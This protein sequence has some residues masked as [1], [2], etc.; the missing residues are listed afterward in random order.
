MTE[1]TEVTKEELDARQRL[2]EVN[3]Q[4]SNARVIL[5]QI[6]AETGDYLTKREK[7]A[8]ER[9]TKA[10][11]A[12]KEVLDLTKSNYEEV[13]QFAN[14]V[15]SFASAVLG[16]YEK[17][18]GVFK[19]FDERSVEWDAELTKVFESIASQ[20]KTLEQER[21]QID[22]DKEGL[23]RKEKQ[24]EVEQIKIDDQKGTLARAIQRLK[25][26]RV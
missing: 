19:L 4:I 11:E 1:P 14:Q 13:N 15:S 23:A 18:Q 26:N 17:L 5:S 3:I 6:E 22:L 9:I 20:K 25:E 10:L 7:D 24:L 21:I 12:S 8:I 2:A 16:F